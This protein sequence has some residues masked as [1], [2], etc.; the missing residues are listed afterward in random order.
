MALVVALLAPEEE[1]RGA[2]PASMMCGCACRLLLLPQEGTRAVA[3]ATGHMHPKREAPARAAL[4]L[5]AHGGWSRPSALDATAPNTGGLCDD[6]AAFHEAGRSVDGGQ[7]RLS[8]C[9]GLHIGIMRVGI[10]RRHLARC[11]WKP[12]FDRVNSCYSGRGMNCHSWCG[13]DSLIDLAPR[14]NT[15]TLCELS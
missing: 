1:A 7:L 14:R 3:L 12:R 6:R 13:H 5:G 2:A 9:A 15:V 11:V 4:R 8:L 10:R